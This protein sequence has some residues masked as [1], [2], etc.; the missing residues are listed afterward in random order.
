MSQEL[1]LNTP[2]PGTSSYHLAHGRGAGIGAAGAVPGT[3]AVSDPD[4]SVLLKR[5]CHPTVGKVLSDYRII[6]ARCVCRPNG[7]VIGRTGMTEA[8]NGAEFSCCWQPGRE[9][10][11]CMAGG[12]GRGTRLQRGAKGEYPRGCQPAR[13]HTGRR[14]RSR[15]NR[16]CWLARGE[17]ESCPALT[18]TVLI[19]L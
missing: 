10:T 17:Q 9:R 4:T 14:E 19:C 8:V 3:S 1:L 16:G 13:R 12:L 15:E 5:R 7:R 6:F 2:S 11:L 18:G